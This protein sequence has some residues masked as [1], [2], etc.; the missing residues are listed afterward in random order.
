MTWL[1]DLTLGEGS[2]SDTALAELN[3]ALPDCVINV[4]RIPSRPQRPRR[5]PPS[6]VGKSLP[7]LKDLGIVLSPADSDDKIIFIC[8]FDMEQRPSRNCIAQLAN[9]AEQ[10]KEKG[11][12]VTAVQASN[13]DQNKLDQW[14]N[15]ND[16]LFS[17]GM[18]KD[19]A[20]KTKFTWG[21]RSLPWLILT[22][23]KHIVRAEGFAFSELNDRI[24]EVQNSTR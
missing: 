1:H 20:E 24:D 5:V 15:Q 18:I 21:V 17:I 4:Q 3:K 13:V 22:D 8:F 19:D 2:I 11:V 23:H 9:K 14:V 16:I 12:V 10:L 6:L 7:G